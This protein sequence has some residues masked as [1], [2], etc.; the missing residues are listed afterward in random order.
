MSGNGP[1]GPSEFPPGIRTRGDSPGPVPRPDGAKRR[2]GKDTEAEDESAASEVERREGREP[3][4]QREVLCPL[5]AGAG[6]PAQQGRR[7][8]RLQPP[9]VLRV[10]S[11]PEKD[12]LLEVHRVLRGQKCQNKNWRLVL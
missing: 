10:P 6:A 8:P 4:V 5:P 3:G 11:V 12:P 1:R 7:V 2:G 9:R